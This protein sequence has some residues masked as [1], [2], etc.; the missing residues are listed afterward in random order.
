MDH[1]I[2]QGKRCRQRF[3]LLPVQTP[4]ITAVCLGNSACLQDVIFKFLRSFAGIHDNECQ[5]KHPLV[6]TLQRF[7]ELLGI[8]PEDLYIRRHDIHVISVTDRFLLVIDL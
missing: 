1:V 6:L 5:E 3:L 7:K 4:Q 2:T 8:L